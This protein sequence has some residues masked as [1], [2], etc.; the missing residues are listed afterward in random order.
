MTFAFLPPGHSM[1]LL[2]TLPLPHTDRTA[3]ELNAAVTWQAWAGDAAASGGVSPALS[4]GEGAGASAER[5]AHYLLRLRHR[6]AFAALLEPAPDARGPPGPLAAVTGGGRYFLSSCALPLRAEGEPPH[7]PALQR[8]LRDVHV[9][10]P[11][12]GV[13]G[14]V[15]YL[16]RGSYEYFHYTQ[17]RFNDK[18][19]CP[20]HSVG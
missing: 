10:L 13:P 1:P 17:Q 9:G 19:R 2:A 4:A 6:L 7:W 18:V 11:P 12:A 20:R 8:P 5:E 3:E 15:H 16:V 14:G